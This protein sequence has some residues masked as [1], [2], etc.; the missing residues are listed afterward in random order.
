MFHAPSPR[1]R[2]V[3][4]VHE[5]PAVRRH[6]AAAI[7]QC[8]RPV[9]FRPGS[10]GFVAANDPKK[11]LWR[12]WTGIR[13]PLVAG[14]VGSIEYEIDYDS[15]PAVESLTMDNSLNLKLGYTW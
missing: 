11:Q 3:R 10:R 15:Q 1:G 5:R 13:V 8:G 7:G 4:D 2:G 12:S 9:K 14:F 6:L